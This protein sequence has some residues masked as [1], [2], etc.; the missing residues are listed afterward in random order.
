MARAT[1][2]LGTA[3]K[4]TTVIEKNQIAW[5]QPVMYES[6]WIAEQAG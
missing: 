2:S 5:L 6:R 1:F 4:D 3:M